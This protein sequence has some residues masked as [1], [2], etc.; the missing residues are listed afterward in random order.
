[1]NGTRMNGTDDGAERGR[2]YLSRLNS[3]ILLYNGLGSHGEG[4]RGG[5]PLIHQAG[6]VLFLL[7]D[8]GSHT[9]YITG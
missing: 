6:S 9:V 8:V 4:Q 3:S 7:L 1:M 2:T 5:D